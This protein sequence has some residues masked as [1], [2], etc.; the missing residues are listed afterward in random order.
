MFGMSEEDMK[1]LLRILGGF[2]I[3]SFAVP[4]ILAIM[5]AG[6]MVGAWILKNLSLMLGV[7]L[8]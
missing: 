3:I 2:A 6:F 7:S 8:I 5:I 4:F 1:E